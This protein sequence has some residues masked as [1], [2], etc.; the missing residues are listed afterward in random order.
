MVGGAIYGASLL[1][2]HKLAGTHAKVSLGS[3][4]PFLVVITA[5]VG[6][7]LGAAGGR[8][9]RALRERDGIYLTREPPED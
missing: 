8:I 5:I 3:F 7:L 4:P 2:A 6:I 9:A 1:I